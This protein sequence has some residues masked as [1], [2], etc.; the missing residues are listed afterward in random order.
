MHVCCLWAG[1]QALQGKAMLTVKGG[2]GGAWHAN[3]CVTAIRYSLLYLL[4]FAAEAVHRAAGC[5]TQGSRSQ[6]PTGMDANCGI[7]C[8]RQPSCNLLPITTKCYVLPPCRLCDARPTPSQGSPP[9][10]PAGIS[11]N[12]SR[13]KAAADR[14]LASFTRLFGSSPLVERPLPTDYGSPPS[15]HLG[16]GLDCMYLADH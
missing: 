11:H 13:F 12:Q 1:Q 16:F 2:E 6:P 3:A 10:A 4:S 15:C 8:D 5:G 9:A 7:V 14:C